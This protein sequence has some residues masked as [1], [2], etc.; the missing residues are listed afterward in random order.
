MGLI[1][2]D[3]A[4]QRESRAADDLRVEQGKTEAA[5]E[6]A[7]TERRQAQDRLVQMYVSNG[8]RLMNEGDLLGSLPWFVKALEEEKGGPEREEI[9]RMRL[10]AV[11]QQ[12]PRPIQMWPHEDSVTHAE[13]SPDGRLVITAGQGTEARVWD[14]QS[15]RLVGAPLKHN[16]MIYNP[17]FSSDSR[18]VVTASFD[19]TARVWNAHAFEAQCGVPHASFSPDGR[20]V[21]TASYDHSVR[22]WDVQPVQPI[23]MRWSHDQWFSY[24]PDGCRV[25]VAYADNTVRIIDA[26]TGAG[27]APPLEH[28]NS[29]M[30]IP[31]SPDGRQIVTAS[32]DHTAR[33]WDAQRGQ[34]IT[35]PL[36]HNDPVSY[37][38]FSLDGRWAVTASRDQTARVWDAQSG[39]PVTEPLKHDCPVIQAAFSA[40]VRRVV[41]ASQDQTARVWDAQSGQPI[42]PPLEHDPYVYEGT[43][44]ANGRL[45][46]TASEG[47]TARLWNLSSGE[48][49]TKDWS[50]LA[51]LVT[52]QRLDSGGGMVGLEPSGLANT[53]QTLLAKYPNDFVISAQ[54]QLDWHARQ[55]AVSE[56]AREWY[57]ALFH[58]NWLIDARPNTDDLH[59]RRALVFVE[60]NDLDKASPDLNKADHF[61]AHDSSLWLRIGQAYAE[62]DNWELAALSFRRALEGEA[63]GVRMRLWLSGYYSLALVGA[64]NTAEHRRT[65]V[66]LFKRF[67]S[68]VTSKVGDE[69]AWICVRFPD[70][71]ENPARVV[72]LA[73]K[74]VTSLRSAEEMQ[75]FRAHYLRTHAAALFKRLWRLFEKP[76]G[77]ECDEGW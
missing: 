16:G 19:G 42:T 2:A 77:V 74:A 7:K 26:Q 38:N 48:R 41:T 23:L 13:F 14:V 47:G 4:A 61:R 34:P 33:V 71:Q 6:D 72:E 20:Q 15:G 44:S 1:R 10:N 36:K 67:G 32:H 40:D 75:A 27:L 43:L 11:W 62:R 25:L 46:V 21:V 58:L 30:H 31:F 64:G 60:L 39:Q 24:S 22:I 17:S 18:R 3:Q 49:P 63:L 12:C 5:L 76:Y 8:V 68:T 37:A 59:L 28:D 45:L 29:V 69:L 51:E 50:L 56:L 35:P 52:G 54:H 66:N 57:A 70:S 55:A 73:E 53:F 9:H 65:C